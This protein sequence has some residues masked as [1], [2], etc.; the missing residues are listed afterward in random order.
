MRDEPGDWAITSP[1]IRSSSKNK[2]SQIDAV[3][4]LMKASSKSGHGGIGSPEFIISCQANPDFLIVIEC[5]AHQRDHSSVPCGLYVVG[6]DIEES[7]SD[8][9]ARSQRF[10]ADGALHY[11]AKLSREFNVIAIAVSGESKDSCHWALEKI[12]LGGASKDTSRRGFGWFRKK[13]FRLTH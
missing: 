10:A 3:K 9:A 4:K 2:K 13:W 8:Y 7:E 1:Q 11:A 12:P 5:K 6:T